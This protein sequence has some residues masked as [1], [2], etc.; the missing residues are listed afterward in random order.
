MRPSLFVLP[1]VVGL[2]GVSL[3]ACS[4][5]DDTSSSGGTNAAPTSCA[6]DNRKDIYTQGM[7]KPASD[8]EIAIVDSA[9]TPSKSPAQPGQVQ[10][11]MN[12]I[13]VEVLDAAKAP[14]DGATVNLNL[15]MPDHSHGS[16]AVP[17]IT[18]QGTGKYQITNVWL[19]MAGLW[20][21]TVQVKG[22]DGVVKS[23]DF[24][25]CVDG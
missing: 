25:F 8:L 22:A 7:M 11:G 21:F 2:L 13:T 16:A 12:T 24:N 3:T 1:V 4:G 19:P 14:V 6:A 5:D 9:F 18:A 10:K 23:T 15:W 17:V 20:R